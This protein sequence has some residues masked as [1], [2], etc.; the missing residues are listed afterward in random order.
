MSL[1]VQDDVTTDLMEAFYGY[2][3]P[4]M[5]CGAGVGSREEGDQMGA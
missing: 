5:D 4:G 1:W 2:W 3:F